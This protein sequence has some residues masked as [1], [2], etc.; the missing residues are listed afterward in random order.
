MTSQEIKTHMLHTTFSAIR[1]GAAALAL[2]MAALPAEPPAAQRGVR[3]RQ[4]PSNITYD[5]ELVRGTQRA[6]VPVNY[7]FKSGDRF[8][9][10]VKVAAPSYVYVLNRTFNGAPA[11][12]RTNRQ[13]RLVQ[14]TAAQ[15]ASGPSSPPAP[16][17]APEGT[18]Y[19]LVY[20]ASGNRLLRPG[21][22]NTIPGPSQLLEMDEVPGIEKLLIIVSPRPIDLGKYFDAATG[23]LRNSPV[24]AS[25][26]GKK[27]SPSDVLGKLNND[28]AGMAANSDAV[29]ADVPA[30]MIVFVPAN[31][32][33][34]PSP[35][36]PPAPVAPAPQASDADAPKPP[37]AAPVP[38]PAPPVRVDSVG[39]PKK[40]TQPF[41]VEVTLSHF[42]S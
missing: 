22:V 9:L 10:R 4:Q 26:Q 6:I 38:R 1:V 32:P 35:T 16:S 15:P 18:P 27:D 33:S 37:S 20:P 23:K 42:P 21:V 40:P 24:P 39:V 41:L 12:L 28:L 17:P 25:G 19:T 2:S 14:D 29:E 11:E 30:R 31:N 13:I 8:A 36:A 34:K 3:L 5:V 7:D